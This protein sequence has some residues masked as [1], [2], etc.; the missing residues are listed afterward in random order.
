MGEWMARDGGWTGGREALGPGGHGK[1]RRQH[2]RG[3]R[4]SSAEG[5][6]VQRAQIASGVLILVV[7]VLQVCSL[8][9]G[10][11][12]DLISKPRILHAAKGGDGEETEQRPDQPFKKE[13]EG[14]RRKQ[15]HVL[16]I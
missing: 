3:A 12:G 10:G 9:L 15:L 5:Q 7:H 1:I 11:R 4:C 14:R 13:K 16:L 2:S 6:R 8:E